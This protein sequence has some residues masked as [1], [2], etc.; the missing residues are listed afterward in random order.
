MSEETTDGQHI[1]NVSVTNFM[2]IVEVN[3][4]INGKE[5]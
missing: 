5:L 4:P 2:R 1:I 3:L